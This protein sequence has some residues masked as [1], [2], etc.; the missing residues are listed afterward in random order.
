MRQTN[1]AII[2]ERHPIPTVDEI[3]Y[4][5]NGSEVFSEV[6]YEVRLSPD[7]TG[8]RFERDHNVCNP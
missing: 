5:M 4:N 8:R 1:K 2:R 3:L 6:R 7:R